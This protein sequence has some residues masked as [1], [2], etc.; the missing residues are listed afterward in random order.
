MVYEIASLFHSSS[1]LLPPQDNEYDYSLDG[2][3]ARDY[4]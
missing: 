2:S 4:D 1:L 3:R